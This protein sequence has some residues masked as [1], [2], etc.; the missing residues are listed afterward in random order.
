MPVSHSDVAVDQTER[1]YSPW[2]NIAVAVTQTPGDTAA[3][4]LAGDLA[5]HYDAR[6]EAL[7]LIVMTTTPMLNPWAIIADP[8]FAQIYTNLREAAQT[9]ATALRKT[10]AGMGVSGEVRTLEALY[11]DPAW[12]VSA[13]ARTSDLIVIARPDDEADAAIVHNYFATLLQ[14]TGRPILVVPS[15]DLL[16][17][18]PRHALVAWADTPEAARALHDALPLLEQCQSVDVLLVD[19]VASVLET[20]EKR[21]SRVIHVLNAHGV[22]ARIVT[23]KSRGKSVGEMILKEAHRG[24]AELIVAGGYGHGK[25]REWALGGTTRDLFHCSPVPVLFAH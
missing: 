21:G 12:L 20:Q 23:C 16:R 6:L 1:M 24:R 10:I 17:F 4:Q 3:L 9:N 25:V 14:E 19:P 7:Q 13:A 18:P 11:V 15:Y 2:R 5:R 22:N 8:G